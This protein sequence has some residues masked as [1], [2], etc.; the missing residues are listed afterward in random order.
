[1]LFS[2]YIKHETMQ[3]EQVMKKILLVLLIILFVSTAAMAASFSIDEVKE[4]N[5]SGIQK[6]VFDLNTP[7]CALCISTGSQ[8]YSFTG[9]G[10]T[11]RLALSLEGDLRSNNKKAVPSLITERKGNTLT[12][13]LYKENNL[14][15]GLVQSGS[16]LFSAELPGYFDGDIEILTSSGD[17]KVSEINSKSLLVNSSS[18]DNELTGI[19]AETIEIDAS[20]GDIIAEKLSAIKEIRVKASSGDIHLDELISNSADVRASS[21]RINIGRLRAVDEIIVHASS[22]RITAEYL[23]AASVSIDAS[24]GKITIQEL[25]AENT[26]IE[27]SSGNITVSK[28][29][30]GSSNFKASSGKTTI[31]VA[32]FKG[33]INIRSSSGDVNLTLPAGSAFSADLDASS[34]KIRSGFKLLGDVSGERNNEIRGDANGGGHSIRVKASSGDITIEER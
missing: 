16:V 5:L 11:E 25:I 22:G 27:A 13:K 33:D 24:T 30:A 4:E 1:M 23:E 3:K 6:I 9:G 14:F 10:R 2:T 17:S 21:G 7:N 18:G 34:G 29:L 12:V 19:E 26:G 20:S 32:E 31:E 28:L 15:F 8:S